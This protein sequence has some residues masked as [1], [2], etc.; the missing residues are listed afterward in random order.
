M[1]TLVCGGSAADRLAILAVADRRT[2]VEFCPSILNLGARLSCETRVVVVE[3][4]ADRAEEFAL[5]VDRLR[6]YRTHV[7]LMADLSPAIINQIVNA[8]GALPDCQILVNRWDTISAGLQTV[9]TGGASLSSPLPELLANVLPPVRS[10]LQPIV[11][12]ALAVSQRNGSVSDLARVSGIAVRTLESRLARDACMSPKRL[13]MWTLTLNAVWRV[14][15]L[16]IAPKAAAI[17]GGFSTER[18]LSNRV[19]RVT[20][21]RLSHV[22]T[23]RGIDRLVVAFLAALVCERVIGLG[24]SP[25]AESQELPQRGQDL[26]VRSPCLGDADPPVGSATHIDAARST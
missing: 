9:L 10:V 15:R 2:L 4:H 25:K 3:L 13:L 5:L 22:R 24:Q 18:A 1:T 12:N 23:H 19:E 7:L 17:E 8:V 6:R 20:G 14:V 16:G 11:A 21:L 26:T